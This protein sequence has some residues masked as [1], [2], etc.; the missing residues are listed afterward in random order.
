MRGEAANSTDRPPAMR[1]QRSFLAHNLRSQPASVS[2][3]PG[4]PPV[5]DHPT[6]GDWS[7]RDQTCLI[8]KQSQGAYGSASVLQDDP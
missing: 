8:L 2:P 6:F 1:H 5:V 7:S 3:S 4:T